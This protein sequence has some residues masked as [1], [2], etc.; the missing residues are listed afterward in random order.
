[1]I[2]DEQIKEAGME[3]DNLLL[4]S[5]PQRGDLEFS[6][7]FEKKMDKL[8]YRRKNPLAHCNLFKTTCNR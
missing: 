6:K 5:L 2:T 4:D 8:I 1:M 3:L 7:R